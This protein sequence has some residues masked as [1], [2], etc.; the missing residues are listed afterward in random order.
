VR[1]TI[2]SIFIGA[3]LTLFGF[4]LDKSFFAVLLSFAFSIGLMFVWYLYSHHVNPYVMA[5]I[6]RSH[7]IEKRL[8]DMQYEIELHYSIYKTDELLNFKGTSITYLLFSMVMGMWVARIGLG[9]YDLNFSSF[10]FA[11]CASLLV[12]LY[13]LFL[14]AF[15]LLH[16]KYNPTPWGKE[17]KKILNDC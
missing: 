2:G 9:I 17:I 1:W 10:E 15:H 16:K 5:S 11:V 4:S 6:F 7:A 12:L 13:C 14:I 8:R 3:S